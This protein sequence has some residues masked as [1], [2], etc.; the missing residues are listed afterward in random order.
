MKINDTAFLCGYFSN[1]SS[2]TLDPIAVQGDFWECHIS[3]NEELV[4]AKDFY[5]PEFV[6]FMMT[7]VHSYT[8]RY[9]KDV[10]LTMRDGRSHSVHLEELKLYCFPFGIVM[11]SVKVSQ[12][13]A[14]MQD[15]LDA[16]F[17]LRNLPAMKRETMVE[18]MSLVIDPL[19]K[20]NASLGNSSDPRALIECGNKQKIFHTVL[21]SEQPE[22][23][24]EFDRL[25]YGA[26]TLSVYKPED[27]YGF[28]KE[29]YGS[30]ITS[31]RLNVFNTWRALSILDIFTIVAYDVKEY[32][33]KV[34]DEE[35]FGKIY[36]YALFRKFFLFRINGDFRSSSKDISLV[37]KDLSRYEKDY[38]FHKILYNFLPELVSDS[39]ER[40]LDLQ[41][42]KTKLAE[43][44][45]RESRRKEEETNE[46]MNLFLGIIT[47]LTL[48]SAVWDFACLMD[49]VFEFSANI[50]T[51][52]GIRAC[53]MAL[54]SIVCLLLLI[55]RRKK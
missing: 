43:I 41:D 5:Y 33:L 22:D 10:Q 17:M 30:I 20:L 8:H 48:F 40:G 47:C 32:M 23:S 29:Y 45:D 46:K 35:Y 53:A 37:R 25:L 9:D 38:E 50:G 24:D 19:T 21:M 28:S 54:L 18:Y 52:T 3:T 34:W 16:L 27:P 55:A 36:L 6:D 7:E 39:M 15:A 14:E 44:I 13:D 11:Y 49:G 12:K 42:E 4:S 1:K 26:G 31:S 2:E 51:V